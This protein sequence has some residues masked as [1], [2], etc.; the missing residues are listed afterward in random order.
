M[1]RYGFYIDGFNVY[2]ALNDF[3]YYEPDLPRTPD[4]KRYPYHKYKWLNYRKLAESVI[5]SR[6]T[7]TRIFFFTTYAKWKWEQ[8][9]DIELRHRQYIHALQTEKI[10]V[11]QGR[12]M[13]RQ[14]RCHLCCG[15][16]P[17]HVE[18]RTDV[19]IALQLLG[20]AI[21]DLYDRAIIVSADSDLLPAISAVHKYTPGK[22]VGVM[23]PIRRTSFDLRQYA[24]FRLKMT[25]KLLKECQFPDK[26][27]LP[28]LILRRP[29]D[30]C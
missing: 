1:A 21:E 6:D 7:I 3:C 10:V 14:E 8:E 19:N 26:I 5:K 24:D 15:V 30:W 18:K 25:E 4:N 12:F 9:P 22:L 11:I 13:H 20:D 23:F 29:E 16:Y 27:I 17:D 2:H 28:D